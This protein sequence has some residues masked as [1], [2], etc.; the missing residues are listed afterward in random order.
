MIPDGYRRYRQIFVKHEQCGVH[1]EV[2]LEPVDG[3]SWAEIPNI[4][5]GSYPCPVCHQRMDL[6]VGSK[7]VVD[8]PDGCLLGMLE[9]P[10]SKG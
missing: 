5:F 1:A 2:W 9:R 7:W 10:L 6:S 4:K 8:V 3:K